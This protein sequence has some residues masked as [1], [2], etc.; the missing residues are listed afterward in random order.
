MEQ[1]NVTPPPEALLPGLLHFYKDADFVTQLKVRF[2]F[3]L[4]LAC[5]ATYAIILTFS[6]YFQSVSPA[7]LNISVI[8]GIATGLLLNIGCLIL[9][10][11]GYLTIASH[12]ILLTGFG[13]TWFVMYVDHF[14]IVSR[15]DSI[16]YV[17]AI[18]SMV[19][20]VVSRHAKV[21][22]L[23]VLLNISLMVLF[24]IRCRDQMSVPDSSILDFFMDSTIAMLL[25]GVVSYNV[26]RIHKM[27]L[28]Q[29]KANIHERQQAEKALSQQTALLAAQSE[30]SFDGILIVDAHGK[31]ISWNNR[32]REMWGIPEEILHSCSDRDAITFVLSRLKDPDDFIRKVEHLYANPSDTNFEEI[33]LLDG[34]TFERYSAAVWGKSGEY[35]GRVWYFRDITGRK[36]GEDALR[37]SEKQYRTLF[38]SSND[39]ILIVR[40]ELVVDCNVSALKLFQC[41]RDQIIDHTIVELSPEQQP[42]GSNSQE[43]IRMLFSATMENSSPQLEWVHK[44]PDD[45]QFFT[46]VSISTMA[47]GHTLHHLAIIRDITERKRAE[48]EHERLQGQLLQAQKMESVGRLA[49]GVAH[50]F[51]NMLNVII[52]YAELATEEMPPENRCHEHLLAIRKAAQRSADLTSQLLAFARKQVIS[53]RTI[54]LNEIVQD[55]LQMLARLIGEDIDLKWVPGGNILLVKMDPS[56]LDQILA[57]LCVNARD[58]I[59]GVGKITIETKGVLFDE[60]SCASHVEAVPGQYV[61]LSISDNGC[62]M[63]KETLA[64]LFEPFFTTKG[65]GY[66]TGLGL[67][68][69]YGII[70][71]NNGFIKVCSE[72]GQGTTFNIYF[73]RHEGQSEHLPSTSLQQGC[74]CGNE[75][76]LLVEDELAI[77]NFS[78]TILE[79]IGYRILPARTPGEAIQ[80]AKAH[81]GQIH[82]LISDVI[83]PEMNGLELSKRLREIHPKIRC[84]FISG[85]TSNVIANQGVLHE[86]VN[87]LQKPFSMQELY[88]KVRNALGQN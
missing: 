37:R 58:A 62:G 57:N 43:K 85:Y 39:A 13:T 6:T 50:D 24:L 78:R 5:T 31:M 66:G 48:E 55:M 81:S 23:Y 46:E 29:A 64:H 1:L 32:F 61:L 12:A 41:H 18:F 49:G 7:G 8:A 83:M 75:T 17:L 53:P 21:I 10:V 27:S 52:G 60:A 86:G 68:T 47:I 25:I 42:D 3:Y 84:L 35:L 30:A 80:M 88:A 14:D 4:N 73:P 45:T 65:L 54:D 79:K 9:L 74:P 69:V 19:P 71:Q 76:V 87:F 72:P 11:R 44:R 82:L 20:L 59:G 2:F 40:Q 77:L 22:T 26:F 16:V 36:Q 67:A 70:K 51:N 15:L 56:Q 38:Q 63:G 33:S 34:K 28:D